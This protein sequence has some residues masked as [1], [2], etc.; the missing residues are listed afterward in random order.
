MNNHIKIT[1][2]EEGKK[3]LQQII[4]H[5]LRTFENN[6]RLSGNPLYAWETISFCKNP[7]INKDLPEWVLEYLGECA[8]NILDIESAQEKNA[9]IASKVATAV[10]LI[11]RGPHNLFKRRQMEKVRHEAVV[12]A[13]VLETRSENHDN[14]P[15]KISAYRKVAKKFNHPTSLREKWVAFFRDMGKER[16]KTE[17]NMEVADYINQK[18][19]TTSVFGTE[20]EPATVKKWRSEIKV[21]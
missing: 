20:I 16:D 17:I 19:D 5:N 13:S 15:A 7:K 21:R 14:V 3:M 1:D 6:Y 4:T 12:F 9:D 11:K 18:Y 2:K 8:I 10:G